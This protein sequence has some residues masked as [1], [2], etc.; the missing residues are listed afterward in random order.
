MLPYITTAR[1]QSDKSPASGGSNESDHP[2][3]AID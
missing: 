1:E 2:E 3:Y